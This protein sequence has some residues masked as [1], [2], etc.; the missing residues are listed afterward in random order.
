VSETERPLNGNSR[1]MNDEENPMREDIYNSL[2]YLGQH[3]L[4]PHYKHNLNEHQK[5]EFQ[6]IY[7]YF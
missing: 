5:I 4:I 6:S 1:F 3:D 2:K 7:G